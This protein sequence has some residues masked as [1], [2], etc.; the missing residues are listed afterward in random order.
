MR[1]PRIYKCKQK[2]KT[3]KDEARLNIKISRSNYNTIDLVIIML[4]YWFI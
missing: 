2:N 4:S 1:Y 3:D